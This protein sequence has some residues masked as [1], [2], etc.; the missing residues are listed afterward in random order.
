MKTL[1]TVFL[2]VICATAQA[3]SVTLTDVERVETGRTAQCIYTGHGI[4]RI[5]EVS[6]S[7]DCP[8]AKTF[9]TKD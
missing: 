4:T 5:I 8:A 1:I 9:N 7:R 3:V 6:A 2:M